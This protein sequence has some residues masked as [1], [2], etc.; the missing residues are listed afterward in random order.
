MGFKYEHSSAGLT[1]LTKIFPATGAAALKDASVA[2]N[3]GSLVVA[4]A[5]TNVAVVGIAQSSPVAATEAVPVV[6]ALPDVEFKVGKSGTA[7]PVLGG[8]YD[9]AA[10]GLTINAD[11]ITNPKWKVVEKFADGEYGGVNISFAL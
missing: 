4:T 1:P 9:T 3:A 8:K 2:L 5:D 10:D 7:T 11:D 6:M